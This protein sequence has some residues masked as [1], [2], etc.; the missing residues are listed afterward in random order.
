MLQNRGLAAS[1]LKSDQIRNIPFH[2]NLS[3]R[4]LAWANLIGGFTHARIVPHL[5]NLIWSRGRVP[6][7]RGN[8]QLWIKKA[9]LG[10]CLDLVLPRNV[11]ATAGLPGNTILVNGKAVTIIRQIGKRI[12]IRVAGPGHFTILSK[13]PNQTQLHF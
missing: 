7:P 12:Y 3:R 13:S 5:G 9:H 6:T 4:T 10:E 2:C 8:I 1:A 11:T